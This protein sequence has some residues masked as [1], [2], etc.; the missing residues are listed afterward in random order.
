MA[1]RGL[2]GGI[3]LG[4]SIMTG[5]EKRRGIAVG[6][7]EWIGIGMKRGT[8]AGVKTALDGMKTCLR[9]ATQT[10][11]IRTGGETDTEML[12]IGIGAGTV[13]DMRDT[14]LAVESGTDGETTQMIIVTETMIDRN[15]QLIDKPF[16]C[17]IIKTIF[18]I[19]SQISHSNQGNLTS[20]LLI[21][22]AIPS[23]FPCPLQILFNSS[24]I[25][26]T[27]PSLPPSLRSE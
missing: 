19:L 14:V 5:T 11:M 3:G 1:R 15:I 6:I 12:D 25:A 26:L 16:L 21:F 24:I 7:G 13:R 22:P 4:I 2:I 18:T 23:N 27:T 20:T 9:N 10:V 17:M 8:G